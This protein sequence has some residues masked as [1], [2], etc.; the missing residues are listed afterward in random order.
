MN[1]PA[2]SDTIRSVDWQ[3]LANIAIVF[4]AVLILSQL[5]EMRRTA[6]A[7]AYGVARE[8]LQDE[9]VRSARRTVFRLGTLEKSESEWNDAEVSQAEIV[10]HTYDSVGQMV[11]YRLLP[12]N[13]IIDSW[14]PSLR[15]IWPILSPM[16]IRYRREW[17]SVE[18]WDDFEWLAHKALAAESK[19]KEQR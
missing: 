14:G 13:I 5:N 4:T 7:Q 12:K 8:I 18:S 3:T 15:I 2:I 9:D 16:V 6:H 10:C 11:R 19:R 17:S 1:L